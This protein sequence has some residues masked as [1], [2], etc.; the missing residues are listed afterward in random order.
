MSTNLQEM[1]DQALTKA[2]FESEQIVQKYEL[3][4]R[5]GDRTMKKLDTQTTPG[6]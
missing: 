6:T 1:S 4:V 5:Y 3:L 2:I